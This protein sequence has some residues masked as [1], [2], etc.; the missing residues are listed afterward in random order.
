LE[1]LNYKE[2]TEKS[3]CVQI[4]RHL[5]ATDFKLF[6]LMTMAVLLIYDEEEA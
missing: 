4:L 3:T 5:L 1:A 6:G 2:R